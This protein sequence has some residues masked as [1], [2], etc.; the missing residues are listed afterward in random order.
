MARLL[1]HTRAVLLL[2]LLL[3]ACRGGDPPADSAAGAA[4]G[5][6]V[7]NVYSHRHYDTDEQLFDLFTRETGIR[8]NV[9]TAPADE[10]IT[11]LEA[12]GSASPADVLITVDAGRLHRAK[13]RGLLQGITSR[14][15]EEVIPSHLRD[16]DG[17][18]FGFTQRARVVVYAVDR[19]DPSELSTYADLVH[20]RWRGRILSRS[21]GNVY[22]QSLMAAMIARMG[23]EAAEEWARGV[24]ANFAR[25]PQGADRDQIRD[26]AAGV[27]DLALVNT[28][29]LG[30][31]LRSDAPADREAA[32]RVAVFFPDQGEGEAGTHVN[33]SGAGVAAHAPNRE[34]AIR[35]LEFM[36]SDEAQRL[37]A[38]GNSEYP[39]KAGVP[40]TA[41][42]QAWGEFRRDT[43]PLA[44]L[45]ELNTEAVRALDRAGWR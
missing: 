25:P 24:V 18:W 19:V 21:S 2:P 20:P 35:L 7:V 45:G 36:V 27:A 33:V 17:Q 6:G 4:T 26:V 9:V 12:E 40:W 22:T 13:E 1:P 3:A 28:Y 23:T 14:V 42:L 5:A 11:R 41:T 31:M 37:F 10:L 15:L 34:N 16:P 39:V 32:A 44:R 43:L 38:E 30:L 29:Y 8:V